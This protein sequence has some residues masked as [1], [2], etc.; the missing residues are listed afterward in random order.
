MKL[1]FPTTMIMIGLALFISIVVGILGTKS[2]AA[3]CNCRKKSDAGWLGFSVTWFL[4]SV[5]VIILLVIGV[6]SMATNP[7]TGLP[8]LPSS[9]LGQKL[10]ITQ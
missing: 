2:G 6:G 3:D 10:K 9:A 7:K 5:A 4:T 8:W 1:A